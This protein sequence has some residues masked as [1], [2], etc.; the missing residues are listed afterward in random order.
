MM[1]SRAMSSLDKITRPAAKL[2]NKNNIKLSIAITITFHFLYQDVT[3][4]KIR[5]PQNGNRQG[6]LC[7]NKERYYFLAVFQVS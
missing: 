2:I 4:V 7:R 5:M 1:L 3:D 6:F